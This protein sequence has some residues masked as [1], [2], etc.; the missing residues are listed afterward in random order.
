M[1]F[2]GGSNTDVKVANVVGG[3]GIKN[4]DITDNENNNT[5][6]SITDQYV[7]T[8]I[9]EATDVSITGNNG[10]SGGTVSLGGS[11][12]V[13]ISGDL[14]L[15]SGLNASDG[16]TIWDSTNGYIP[17]SALSNNSVTINTSNGLSAGSVSLGDSVS[18][19]ISGDLNLDSDLE[20]PDGTTI[21]DDS[22]GYIPESAVNVS[23]ADAGSGLSKTSGTLSVN[24]GTGIELDGSDNIQ[25]GGS[26]D[27]SL[28]DS[29]KILLGNSDDMAVRYDSG[30][31]SVRWSDEG[32]SDRMNLDRTTG[33][34]EIEGNFTEGSAL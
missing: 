24:L 21:W 8:S 17:T 28:D 2:L 12:T 18:I 5:I 1:A 33:D 3:L 7:P 4:G 29:T 10:L 16:T 13:G 11:T 6:Y 31:D 22:E 20:A 26:S 23:G 27:I 19:G 15:D 34:L 14:N 32:T 30:N 25:P 9:L